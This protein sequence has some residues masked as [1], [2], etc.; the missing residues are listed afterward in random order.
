MVSIGMLSA[1]FS[2]IY[3]NLL[4]ER[5]ARENTRVRLIIRISSRRFAAEP[6]TSGLPR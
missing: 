6:S 1:C 2:Y 5:V 4:R 3:P